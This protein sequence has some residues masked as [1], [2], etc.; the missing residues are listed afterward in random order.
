MKLK[1][2]VAIVTGA[3]RGIGRAHALRLARLGADVVISDIDLKSHQEF[4]EEIPAG[5]V[6][7]EVKAL[8][9]EAIGI[10]A[11]VGK[12]DQ[13]KAMVSQTLS[14]FG[15]IDILINNAGGLAGDIAKSFA[16]SVSI[17]DLTATMD[18]NLTGTIF[19]CQAVAETMKEQKW[20]RI[21]TT[22]SQAGL[23]AQ[24]NGV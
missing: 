16:S 20:G 22:S 7:E 9:A 11:D 6:V 1:D 12:E 24:D 17:E 21:V 10:Q 5:S 15:R 13:V 19:C 2:K 18:R 23:Q 4:D 8:G 14:E 3:A